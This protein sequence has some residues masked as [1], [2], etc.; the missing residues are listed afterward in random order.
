MII[1][2]GVST[3]EVMEEVTWEVWGGERSRKE[4]ECTTRVLS[5]RSVFAEHQE[6]AVESV[7]N[8]HDGLRN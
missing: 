4:N 5:G 2:R 3:T 7:D 8:V 1:R 6:D